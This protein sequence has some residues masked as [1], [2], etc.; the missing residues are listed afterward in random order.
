MEL[1][2]IQYFLRIVDAGS[3]SKAAQSLY[4]TQ[5]TLSRF[6][7]KLEEELGV[8]LFVREKNN[9]LTLTPAGKTYLQTARK[10]DAQLQKLDTQ[11]QPYR[12]EEGT[13]VFGISGD[14]LLPFARECAEKVKAQYPE[15]SVSCECDSSPVIQQMVAD[16]SVRIGLCAFLEKDPALSYALCNKTEINLVVA[17][18]HPLAA[19][20][21]RIP[22]QEACRISLSQLPGD[23]GFAMMRGNTVLRRTVETYLARQKY[24]PDV[25]QTYSRH[26]S[27]ARVVGTSQL[28]GFCPADNHSERLAYLAL[29]PPLYY[30]HGVCWQQRTSLH[31]AERL[32]VSLL[33]RMPGKRNLD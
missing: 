7:E 22:G 1:R 6:L 32:L 5:P 12:K 11:L 27:I 16:G 29:D 2:K 33:K 9:A 21:Y 3:L 8:A 13:L 17:K 31:P 15:L 26:G 25:R 24:V 20:S 19:R 30:S 10:I 28:I 23:A 18:D 4:L 14:Y